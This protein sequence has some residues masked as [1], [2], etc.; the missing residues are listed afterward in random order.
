MGEALAA[1]W[2]EA[3]EMSAR[4]RAASANAAMTP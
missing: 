1:G 2:V 4:S 3:D